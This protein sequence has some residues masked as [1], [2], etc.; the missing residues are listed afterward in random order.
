ML[1]FSIL[2]SFSLLWAACSDY[3]VDTADTLANRNGL[4]K[5]L[6]FEPG[7][8]VTE[9]YYYS[10][11]LGADVRYQLS[12]KCPKEVVEKI[13]VDL[14]LQPKPEGYSGLAPRDDLKWWKPNS[15]EGLQMWLKEAPDKQ[16]FWELW[17]S[18]E[19]GYAYYQEYSI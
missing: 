6:G 14:S 4:A 2:L 11:E 18:E 8:D 1:R 13:I 12:F 5:H 15:T 7:S 17:Y 19:E 3:D 16:Y 9:V 10:D